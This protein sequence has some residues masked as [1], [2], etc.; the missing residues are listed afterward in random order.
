[1]AAL[2]GIVLPQVT[3]TPLKN[4]ST[5]SV[6]QPSNI[7]LLTYDRNRQLTL[8][9]A[10]P[11]TLGI[12]NNNDSISA[13][14]AVQFLFLD[15][16]DKEEAY[17]DGM[18]TLVYHPLQDTI[19]YLSMVTLFL[20]FFSFSLLLFSLLVFFLHQFSLLMES[21]KEKSMKYYK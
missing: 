7:L 21:L 2:K 18:I 14:P 6:E 19:H 13:T 3:R 12:F 1:M 5:S 17:G 11:L 20:P 16:S 8:Q 4:I 15:P 9:M 10:I